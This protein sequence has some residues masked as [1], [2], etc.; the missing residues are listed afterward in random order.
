MSAT[1]LLRLG[2]LPKLPV[3]L[4]TEAAECGLACLAMVASYHGRRIDVASLRRS[5]PV[6]LKGTTLAAL[7]DV[8]HRLGFAA[9]AV[10]AEL[11]EIPRLATPCILHFDMDHFVVLRRADRRGIVVHDPARGARRLSAAEASRAFTGVALELWPTPAFE[12]RDERARVRLRELIGSVTGL[13]R[14]L[15]QIFLLA[16]AIEVFVAVG[17]LFV[18]WVVDHALPSGARDMLATL[19]LG[20]GLLVILQHAVTAFRAWVIMHLG[21][22]LDLQW[23]ANAFGHL[24]ELPLPYFEKRHLGDIVSRFRSIDAIQRTLTTA[25]VEAV[26][27]GLTT[28]VVLVV[29]FLYSPR[30]ACVSVGA[31]ALYASLRALW[32]RP[33]RA[34]VEE[35]IVHA[36]KQESHFLETARG[37][38]SIKLFQRREERRAAWI[39]LLVDQLNAGL[40]AQRLQILHRLANGLSFGVEHVLVVWLGANLVLDGRFSV[41]MLMAFLSYRQQLAS[42]VGALIDKGVELK[43]LRVQGERLADILLTPTERTDGRGRLLLSDLDARGAR[44]EIRGLRFR[45]AEHEPPVLDGV[46]LDVEAGEAVVIV[47]PSGCGKST[48]LHLILGILTPTGGEVRIAGVNVHRTGPDAVRHLIGSV[49]QNDMLFAGSIADNISFFD[50]QPDQRRVEECARL[51]S[52]HDEIAALPMGYNTFVGYMGQVLSGGQQQRV[53]LARALYKRPAILVLDEATSHLDVRRERLVG[54]SIGALAMTRIIVA[55]RPHTAAT[56]DRIVVLDRGR[57]VRQTRV[58]PAARP[59]AR[60]ADGALDDAAL[61]VLASTGC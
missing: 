56:A 36:A 15:G 28:I 12:R 22:L 5:H 14:S 25:F 29:V 48:L 30:L 38:R 9:R 54:A 23:Q 60:P 37:I 40:R 32:I 43:M 24:L 31:I 58:R 16:A 53:L 27:D 44:V 33:L 41:G 8:A 11:G 42:R 17:P 55:H 45:Y 1:E 26:V 10:R 52:I 6:S 46:E 51:A 20:F 4:Q 21:A 61:A 39:A 19:A 59:S 49:M 7:I 35:Q 50:T 34:A 13:R 18:Q 47:G 2:W 3:L 57:I